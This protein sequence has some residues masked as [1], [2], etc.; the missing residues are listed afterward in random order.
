MSKKNI[1]VV[2]V[3]DIEIIEMIVVLIHLDS[4]E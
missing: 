3:R 4:K 2:D 1:V